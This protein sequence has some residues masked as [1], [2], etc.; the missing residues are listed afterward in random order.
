MAVRILIVH[1]RSF[2]VWLCFSQ[3]GCECVP[4]SSTR[5]VPKTATEIAA[6][7]L[8][9]IFVPGLLRTPRPDA[10]SRPLLLRRESLRLQLHHHYFNL[11]LRVCVRVCV[12]KNMLLKIA[13]WEEGDYETHCTVGLVICLPPIFQ[14]QELRMFW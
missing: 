10:W 8:S 3:G 4:E 9:I 11:R 12:L 1:I 5:E 13:L 14:F 6:T 7:Q 2:C